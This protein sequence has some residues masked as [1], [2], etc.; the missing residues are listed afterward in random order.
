MYQQ[1]LLLLHLSIFP[2]EPQRPVRVMRDQG[3]D[4]LSQLDYYY[5]LAKRQLLRYQS[6]TSHLYP[7]PATQSSHMDLVSASLPIITTTAKG[8][9]SPTETSITGKPKIFLQSI[10]KLG[11]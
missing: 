8:S 9:G 3:D 10:K 11:W 5:G 7:P 4:V 6:A 1:S 2:E